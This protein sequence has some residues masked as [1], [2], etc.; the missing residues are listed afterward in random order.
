MTTEVRERKFEAAIEAA[1]VGNGEATPRTIEE[2]PR[3]ATAATAV[4]ALASYHKRLSAAYDVHLC[5]IPGDVMD[6]IIGTQPKTWQ[7]FRQHHGDDAREKLLKR[8][9]R[10]V[11]RRGVVEVLRGGVKESGCHFD[12]AYFQPASGLNP[13][14]Q[15]LYAANIFGVVRQLYYSKDG[16]QSVDLVLFLNGLPI[17]TAELK[18]PLN[19]QNVLDAIRQYKE[20]RLPTETL[21]S[22][23]RCM[24][25]SP[26]IQTWF[27]SRPVCKAQRR[28][29]CRSIKGTMAARAIR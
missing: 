25:I 12:L 4:E 14:T 13:E 9:S 21:F 5:L 15:R 17:F 8:I 22:F 28:S 1:L 29:F 20:C 19:G 18:N 27:T 2:K 7:Q 10:E 11:E 24:G 26:L 6:F 16:E 3:S 23:R